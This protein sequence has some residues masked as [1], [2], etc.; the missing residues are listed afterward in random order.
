MRYLP[1][2]DTYMRLFGDSPSLSIADDHVTACIKFI[3]SLYDKSHKEYNI[4]YLWYKLFAQKYL[5][6]DKLPPTSDSSLYHLQRANYQCY[7]WKSACTPFCNYSVLF[8]MDGWRAK[9][10]W[11]KKKQCEMLYQKPL[12]SKFA[13]NAKRGVRRMPVVVKRQGLRV[14]MRV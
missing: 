11:S 2:H 7:A 12:L 3:Y 10:Y 14:L 9:K 5:T 1:I 4:N 8:R 6:G 13:A